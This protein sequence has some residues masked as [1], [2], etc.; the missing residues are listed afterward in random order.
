[1]AALLVILLLTSG[2]VTLC[3]QIHREYY[4]VNVAT[5][6]NE[7]QSYCRNSYTDLATVGSGD[8]MQRLVNTVAASGVTEE[9]W[10]DFASSWFNIV[11]QTK[12]WINAQ[13]D[14]R[15]NNKDL[16][17]VRSQTEN[18]ALQQIINDTFNGT[19]SSVWIGLFRDEWKWS[20]QSNSSFRSWA[21]GQPNND[22]IQSKF[23]GASVQWRVQPDGN[24][25]H[26]EE[27]KTVKGTC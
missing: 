5:T 4:L 11:F 21:S 17:S 6:W 20:D 2:Y 24:I 1:M 3:S 15:L 19:S 7:A 8:D 22:G 26:K 12:N 23:Q 18:L 27:K 13:Q 14:C 25:F 9:V 16:S 10:I